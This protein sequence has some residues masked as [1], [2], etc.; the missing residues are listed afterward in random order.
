MFC[1]KLVAFVGARQASYNWN[2][3]WAAG[4]LLDILS[5]LPIRR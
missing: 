5:V 2:A 1:I 4:S 3:M